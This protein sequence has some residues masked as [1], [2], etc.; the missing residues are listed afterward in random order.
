MLWSLCYSKIN[1]SNVKED[2]KSYIEIK[3]FNVKNTVR[4]THILLTM[5]IERGRMY[6]QL[7]V[8]N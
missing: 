7:I 1:G 3:K 2:T 6:Q 8:T 5:T 4:D